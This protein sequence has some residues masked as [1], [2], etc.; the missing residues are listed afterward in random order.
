MTLELSIHQRVELYAALADERRLRIVD[1]LSVSDLAPSEL[2]H[3][4]GIGS[5]LLSHHLRILEDAGLVERLPSSGDG[6]RHYLHLVSQK[7]DGLRIPGP[8]INTDGVLFVCMGNSARSQL[9]AALWNRVSEVPAESAGTH[10]AERVHPL[11][12][13]AGR[14]AGLDLASAH[15]RALDDVP[16]PDLVVTVCD[17]AHEEL[18]DSLDAPRAVHWSVPDPVDVGIPAAFLDSLHDLDRRIS[19]LA[20][21][22]RRVRATRRPTR[23]AGISPRS[24]KTFRRTRS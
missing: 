8:S 7:L 22:V 12:V 16:R 24:P 11:A 18:V 10:P 19:T 23:D 5:N 2:A 14:R 13:R 17:R 20:P 4:L 15:P 9:A 6:R 1:R 3:E 21:R